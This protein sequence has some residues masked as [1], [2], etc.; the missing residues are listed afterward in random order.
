MF[1]PRDSLV[2]LE[3]DSK[4]RRKLA[5]FLRNEIH[6]LAEMYSYQARTVH[7]Y[8]RNFLKAADRQMKELV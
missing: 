8:T 7:Q 3:K 1:D 4:A 5:G 2:D 6:R